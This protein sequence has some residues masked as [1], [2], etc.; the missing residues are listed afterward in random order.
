[1]LQVLSR[2][3]YS[4]TGARNDQSI[5]LLMIAFEYL[6]MS[7]FLS[8]EVGNPKNEVIWVTFLSCIVLVWDA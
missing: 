4:M 1:M 3:Q 2:M 7:V 5:S 6:C 8:L